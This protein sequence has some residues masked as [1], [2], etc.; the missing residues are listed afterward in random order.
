MKMNTIDYADPTN[1]GLFCF[2]NIICCEHCGSERLDHFD[3]GFTGR[4]RWDA[5][6]CMD[7]GKITSNEPQE[8]ED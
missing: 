2:E 3:F 6:E 8:N 1:E 4:Y 7:C 5:F